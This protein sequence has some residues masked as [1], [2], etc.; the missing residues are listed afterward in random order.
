MRAVESETRRLKTR[1][2]SYV[3]RP[4]DIDVMHC[5]NETCQRARISMIFTIGLPIIFPSTLPSGKLT[6]FRSV[7]TPT[8]YCNKQGKR[9]AIKHR[10]LP[11]LPGRHSVGRAHG[12]R[13][14]WLQ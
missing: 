3:G 12:D 13:V 4:A 8:L 11:K 9:T 1:V 14:P 7:I 2:F 10:A 5:G 6:F